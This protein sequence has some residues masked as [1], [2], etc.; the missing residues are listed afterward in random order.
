MMEKRYRVIKTSSGYKLSL[1]GRRRKSTKEEVLQ[2]KKLISNGAG[3]ALIQLV[4]GLS[5]ASIYDYRTGRAG[6]R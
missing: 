3:N 2:L 4:T 6:S 5:R 1:V